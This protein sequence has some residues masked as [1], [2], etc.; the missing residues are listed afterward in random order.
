MTATWAAGFPHS[1]IPGSKLARSSPGL[2][3]TCYV[4]H[5][6]LA[7]RHPPYALTCLSQ[8]HFSLISRQECPRLTALAL[9][10]SAY[11]F[12]SVVKDQTHQGPKN[13]LSGLFRTSWQS[14]VWTLSLRRPI[15]PK[16]NGSTWSNRSYLSH[17]DLRRVFSVEQISLERR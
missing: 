6:L 3:A 12:P 15:G 4:L 7:P 10:P 1:D 16:T 9:L 11:P 17:I 5:R 14:L 13:P 2:F 8:A